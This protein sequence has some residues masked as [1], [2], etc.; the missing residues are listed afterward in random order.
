MPKK[1]APARRARVR[2]SGSRGVSASIRK[3]SKR[4]TGSRLHKKIIFVFLG[5]ATVLLFA[6]LS[7]QIF[8]HN[9]F[10]A[11]SASCIKDLSGTYDTS[12]TAGVFE[13]KT[14]KVPAQEVLAY[15]SPS[16]K[17][18]GE[19]TGSKKIAVDLSTQ[20]LYA[21]EGDQVVMDFPVSTGKWYK[22][23]TGEFNIWVKL[24]YTKMEG[25][26]GSAYYYLPNVP[27][28]M[29]FYGPNANKG[30]GYAIHGAYWHNNFGHPMS[31]GCINMK[32]S[33]AGQIFAWADPAIT[34]WANPATADNPGTDILIYGETPVE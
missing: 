24:R 28:T 21:Y 16:K 18:L 15:T 20:H 27:Y 34:G 25:G 11:N 5:G 10:C 2:V 12:E 23:P 30:S 32:I 22:T 31:H 4:K 6:V 17:V 26:S 13:G 19:N 8:N 9:K 29:F 7:F 1:S 33:D 3:T 14:V